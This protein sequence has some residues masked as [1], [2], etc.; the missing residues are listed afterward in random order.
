M[1]VLGWALVTQSGEAAG[2]LSSV[3]L[4][5]AGDLLHLLMALAG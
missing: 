3:A 1:V 4:T 5:G 2:R